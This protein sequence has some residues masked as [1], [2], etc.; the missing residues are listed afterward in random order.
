MWLAF[1]RVLRTVVS[2]EMATCC[3]RVIAMPSVAA[4]RLTNMY[5]F[6][7]LYSVCSTL[8]HGRRPTKVARPVGRWIG[9]CPSSAHVSVTVHLL[10]F[11]L[12]MGIIDDE[13]LLGVN[14]RRLGLEDP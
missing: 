10:N 11:D 6:V 4:W 3:F 14:F 8:S 12:D 7:L 13:L 2:L 1:E 5:A 9:S